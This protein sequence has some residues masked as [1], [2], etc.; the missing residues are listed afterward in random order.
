MASCG[1]GGHDWVSSHY[2]ACLGLLWAK[3]GDRVMD[4]M[5][6]TVGLGPKAKPRGSRG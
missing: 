6:I 1:R 5:N 3:V 4:T 2:W